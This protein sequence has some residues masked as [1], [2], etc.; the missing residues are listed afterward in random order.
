MLATLTTRQFDALV[1]LGEGEGRFLALGCFRRG[2]GT[3]T[4]SCLN[5]SN[6]VLTFAGFAVMLLVPFYLERASF[7]LNQVSE[8]G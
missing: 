5:L 4:L 8:T 6:A 7:E 3:G 1:I 2:V